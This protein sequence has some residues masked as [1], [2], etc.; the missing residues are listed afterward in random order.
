MKFLLGFKL[1]CAKLL[2]RDL[3]GICII[4]GLFVANCLFLCFNIKPHNM[5]FTEKYSAEELDYLGLFPLLVGRSMLLISDSGIIGTAKEAIALAG[6]Y[7]EKRPDIVPNALINEVTKMPEGI[8][9]V[10]E[11]LINRQKKVQAI[12]EKNELDNPEKISQFVVKQIGVLSELLLQKED[13]SIGES[14]QKW[15]VEIAEKISNAA[16]EGGFLGFGGQRVSDQEQQFLNEIK[17]AFG[18]N[19]FY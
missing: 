13:M 8:S 16:S 19:A 17:S 12:F 6:I 3:F 11:L 5:E 18:Y 10:K 4:L 7:S 9:D 2:R 15:I 14:Y 1:K